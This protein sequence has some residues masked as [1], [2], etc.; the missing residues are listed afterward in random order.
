MF[1]RG[2]FYFLVVS[3][4]VHRGRYLFLVG[5][6]GG[7]GCISTAIAFLGAQSEDNCRKGM[8]LNLFGVAINMQCILKGFINQVVLPCIHGTHL[9]H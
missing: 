5:G 9:E 3:E 1:Q 7:L 8:V 4:G 6:G 2:S